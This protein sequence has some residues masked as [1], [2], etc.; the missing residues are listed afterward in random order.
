MQ[1]FTIIVSLVLASLAAGAVT[2]AIRD[3][4]VGLYDTPGLIHCTTDDCSGTYDV[5][6]S[7][8]GQCTFLPYKNSLPPYGPSPC[9]GV[10]VFRSVIN[11]VPKN[12]TT[13]PFDVRFTSF[14]HS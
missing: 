3:V 5:T 8:F 2:P 4:P 9:L 11:Y 14:A 7:G 13:L 6:N 12:V 1:A 10:S